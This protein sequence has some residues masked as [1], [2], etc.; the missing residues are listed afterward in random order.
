MVKKQKNNFTGFLLRT[1]S[2]GCVN[3]YSVENATT[4]TGLSEFEL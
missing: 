1:V 4:D 2:H 3:L